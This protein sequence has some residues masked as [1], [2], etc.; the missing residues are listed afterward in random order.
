MPAWVNNASTDLPPNGPAPAQKHRLSKMRPNSSENSRIAGMVPVPPCYPGVFAGVCAGVAGATSTTR[1]IRLA[2]ED[3]ERFHRDIVSTSEGAARGSTAGGL[4]EEDLSGRPL[5]QFSLPVV[6]VSGERPLHLMPPR[7]SGKL[8]LRIN[9]LGSRFPSEQCCRS[10]TA[11]F[12][13]KSRKQ[14]ASGDRGLGCIDYIP[15]GVGWGDLTSVNLT[16]CGAFDAPKPG[17]GPHSGG[18]GGSSS[19]TSHQHHHDRIEE[20]ARNLF[21]SRLFLRRFHNS[22][23]DND[24]LEF[25]GHDQPHRSPPAPPASPRPRS[26]TLPNP[27][28]CIGTSATGRPLSSSDMGSSCCG[29]RRRLVERSRQ[30]DPRSSRPCDCWAGATAP[31]SEGAF[32]CDCPRLSNEGPWRCTRHAPCM[33]RLENEAEEKVFVELQFSPD[34]GWVDLQFVPTDLLDVRAHRVNWAFDRWDCWM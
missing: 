1:L 10:L 3:F 18:G 12:F 27:F 32:H 29:C 20:D 11:R 30:Q 6:R 7:E 21:T 17:G 8:E 31:R 16:V 33:F 5:H 28:S 13:K 2:R 34:V 26:F 15:F 19:A 14:G 23:T 9:K 25:S 4:R 24:R 22:P